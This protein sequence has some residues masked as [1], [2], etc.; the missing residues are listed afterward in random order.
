LDLWLAPSE[1]ARPLAMPPEVPRERLDAVRRAF[2][3]MFQ[4]QGFL[5]DARRAGVAID[6]KDGA[7]INALVLRLRAYPEKVIEAARAA[8]AE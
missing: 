4:D 2:M 5:A 6:P 1:V 3:T 7:Y 8:A